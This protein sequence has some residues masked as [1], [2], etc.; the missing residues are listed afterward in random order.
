MLSALGAGAVPGLLDMDQWSMTS[1]EPITREGYAMGIQA[2]DPLSLSTGTW[3][4]DGGEIRF[5]SPVRTVAL[6]SLTL[7]FIGFFRAPARWKPTLLVGALFLILIAVGPAFGASQTNPFYVLLVK[8]FTPLQRLWW[9][10]RALGILSLWLLPLMAWALSSLEAEWKL[11]LV[12]LTGLGLMGFELSRS[13]LIP[14]PISELRIPDVVDCLAEGEGAILELPYGNRPERL[15]FQTVHGRARLGGMLEGNPVFVPEEHTWQLKEDP[16]MRALVGIADGG[17]LCQEDAMAGSSC[18]PR[19]GA[20][21]I[22]ALGEQGFSLVIV[23]RNGLGGATGAGARLDAER[24]ARLQLRELLGEP[25][26][27]DSGSVVYLP[28]DGSFDCETP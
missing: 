25:V 13:S 9:P 6:S 20:E 10:S 2:F 1:W 19:P 7:A 18:L 22:D 3:Y 15:L 12:S 27:M 17:R 24:R 5:L 16:A 8:V 21:E 23:D 28:W 11:G 4:R 14:M 26:F